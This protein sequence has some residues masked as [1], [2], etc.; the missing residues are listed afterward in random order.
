MVSKLCERN[1]QEEPQLRR[2]VSVCMIGEWKV[3]LTFPVLCD[4]INA[5]IHIID[6]KH[7]YVLTWNLE[8]ARARAIGRQH[9][10]EHCSIRQ[11][12]KST[13]WG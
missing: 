10:A 5:R 8:R 7:I 13:M 9:G 3:R 11:L 4:S 6:T 2:G 1:K 12:P